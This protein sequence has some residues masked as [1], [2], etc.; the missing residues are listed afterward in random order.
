LVYLFKIETKNNQEVVCNIFGFVFA[1][2]QRSVAFCIKKR[3]KLFCFSGRS[4]IK[5]QKEKQT[6]IKRQ[7]E[8]ETEK[9]VLSN[10]IIF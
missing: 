3:K 10:S 1:L 7:K 8:K 6:D 4:D 5:R 9:R 2:V